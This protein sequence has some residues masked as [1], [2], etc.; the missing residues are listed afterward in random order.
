MVDLNFILPVFLV[1]LFFMSFPLILQAMVRMRTR[2]AHLCAILEKDK[3]LVIKLLKKKRDDFVRDKADDW[4]LKTSRMRLVEYPIGWPSILNSF[5]QTVS[6]S[7][8]MRGRA[9]PL[10]WEDP[11][12][13]ALSSKELPAVLDPNWLVSLVKGIGEDTKVGKGERMLTMI[14]AGASVLSVLAVIY[15]ISKIGTIEQA[16]DIL[17]ATAR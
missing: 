8:L 12:A 2:G 17:R 15:L 6:C 4:M 7:L 14:A 3:P 9:D 11:P 1:I 10:D 13:G 16:I 5:K